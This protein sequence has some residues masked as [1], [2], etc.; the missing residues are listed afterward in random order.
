MALMD[1]LQTDVIT[2]LMR[3][4]GFYAW[5][6]AE[7]ML[8]ADKAFAHIYEINEIDIARGVP[9][10]FILSRI[11]ED[12]RPR[13][14][15]RIHEVILG[16]EP[17]ISPYRILCPSGVYKSLMSMGSCSRDA[18]G[19][20]AV[21]SGVVIVAERFQLEIEATQLEHHISS[22]MALARDGGRDLTERYLASALRSLKP[23]TS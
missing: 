16:G 12:D 13:L 22:A 7:N 8:T 2:R 10:E 11:V 15:K 5:S 3:G 6:L 9:V 20:P 1:Q 19:V 17:F 18:D 23:S 14:A 21:Y 4:S